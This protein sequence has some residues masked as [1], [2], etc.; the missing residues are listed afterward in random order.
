[1]KIDSLVRRLVALKKTIPAVLLLGSLSLGL[2]PAGRAQISIT[3][4]EEGAN[5]KISYSGSWSTW[6]NPVE[7]VISDF[8]IGAVGFLAVDGTHTEFNPVYAGGSWGAGWTYFVT[9][10]VEHTGDDFG[11]IDQGGTP[12][13]VSGRKLPQGRFS[14]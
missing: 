6:V 12:Y 14:E 7:Q 4:A 9:G 13:L 11:W 3:I 2:V 10:N 8:G 1:M 5:L